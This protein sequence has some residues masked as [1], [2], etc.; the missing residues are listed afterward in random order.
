MNPLAWVNVG[1]VGRHAILAWLQYHV[2]VTGH[3]PNSTPLCPPG[4]NSADGYGL[5]LLT[6]MSRAGVAAQI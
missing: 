6:G 2:F 4:E 1:Q 3:E 5:V